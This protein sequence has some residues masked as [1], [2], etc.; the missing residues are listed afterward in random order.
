MVVVKSLING[1]LDAKKHH[2][3]LPGGF[4]EPLGSHILP[5]TDLMKPLLPQRLLHE[6]GSVVPPPLSRGTGA[7]PASSPLVLYRGSAEF[8]SRRKILCREHWR[9]DA[10][11]YGVSAFLGPGALYFT[12]QKRFGDP[13]RRWNTVIY[14]TPAFWNQRA[15]PVGPGGSQRNCATNLGGLWWSFWSPRGAGRGQWGLSGVLGEARGGPW[16]PLGV[17]GRCQG[18]RWT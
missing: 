13:R 7:R 11:I 14:G 2:N 9:W 1:S 12:R 15:S 4:R 18:S 10:A 3:C 8:C 17:F 16:A 5:I 6:L